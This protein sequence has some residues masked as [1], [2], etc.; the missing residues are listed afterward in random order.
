VLSFCFFL[1]NKIRRQKEEHRV[2]FE[3]QKF[4]RG[5]GEAENST[6]TK[7]LVVEAVRGTCRGSGLG[8]N[9]LLIL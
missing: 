5:D 7:T 9:S 6:G 1:E 4:D 8:S 3:D 2:S